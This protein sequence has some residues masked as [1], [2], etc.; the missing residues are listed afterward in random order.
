MLHST[1][2][3][4]DALPICEHILFSLVTVNVGLWKKFEPLITHYRNAAGRPDLYIGWQYLA[5]R[6]DLYPR[7]EE[8]LKRTIWRRLRRR[9]SEEHTSELQSHSDLVCFTPLFPYTTL[10]RSVNTF[11]FR[12][13]RSMSGCGKSSNRSLHIIVTPQEGRIST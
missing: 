6:R 1:L 8:H 7:G 4:H 5:E 10:F 2:S 3:L 12:S 9:R 11:C 13:L